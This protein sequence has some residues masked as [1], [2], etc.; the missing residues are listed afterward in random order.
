[1]NKTFIRVRSLKDIIITL[2][3]IVLG[4]ILIVIPE[5][6]GIN[7]LG[8]LLAVCGAATAFV[9][10]SQY[11]DLE[12]G[13]KY[14]KTEKFFMQSMKENITSALK[15][16]TSEIDMS[17]EN[18]GNGLRLDIY[19]NRKDNRAYLQLFEYIP[20]KYEPCSEMIEKEVLD[21]KGII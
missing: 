15:R 14:E 11:K 2:I 4:V 5:S 12:S 21:I 17:Q 16:K 8:F 9:L 1:M 20:Y 10:K 6:D 7:I 3:L 18:K 13:I 19:Y